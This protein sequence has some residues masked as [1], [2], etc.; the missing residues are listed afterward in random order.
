MSAAAL[1]HLLAC[2]QTQAVEHDIDKIT[3][4]ILAAVHVS[5]VLGGIQSLQYMH[6]DILRSLN[7]SSESKEQGCSWVHAVIQSTCGKVSFV[8]C[9]LSC[10]QLSSKQMARR[11]V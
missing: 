10:R 9:R 7:T 11:S 5:W 6:C 8:F 3:Q 1:C 2:S 4:Q